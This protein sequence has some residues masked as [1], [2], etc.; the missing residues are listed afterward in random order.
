[1]A[2]PA[3]QRAGIVKGKVLTGARVHLQLK[4]APIGYATIASYVETIA[5]DAVAVLDQLEIAEHVPIA[6]DVAFS[7]SRVAISTKSLKEANLMPKWSAGTGSDQLLLAILTLGEMTADIVDQQ[8]AT[9]VSIEGVRVTS[10]NLAFAARSIV[11]EDV[12][13]VAIRAIDAI[14]A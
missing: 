9:L 8:D 12:A 7:A 1:M 5:Y 4:G 10:H 13:F 2:A 14:E 3:S 6:Y 11:G